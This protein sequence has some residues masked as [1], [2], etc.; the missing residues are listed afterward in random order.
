MASTPANGIDVDISGVNAVGTSSAPHS[1]TL[2]N[3]RIDLYLPNSSDPARPTIIPFYFNIPFGLNMTDFHLEPD[4]N[5]MVPVSGGGGSGGGST[6][7]CSTATI[8]VTNAYDGSPLANAVVNIGSA[9][10]TTDSSGAAHFSNLVAGEANVSAS[11]AGY[12]TGSRSATLSCSTPVSLGL[13][14]SPASGGGAI[15]FNEARI[16]LTWGQN[17]NDLDSHLTGPAAGNNGTADDPNRFH[18]YFGHK[19]ADVANLDVD[20]TTSYGPE[21]ITI[22]PPSGSSTPRPGVYRYSV[23][24]YSGSGNIATSG[25]SVSLN[26]ANGQIREFTPPTDTTGLHGGYGDVWTVFELNVGADGT[27]TLLPINTYSTATSSSTVRST[28]TGFGSVEN[29]V[30]FTRLPAK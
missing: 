7:A 25:A 17:P 28:A 19:Q 12:T 27:V 30:D 13:A 23:F 24:H 16:I 4:L 26:L 5:A 11:L 10:A 20:D 21:T 6:T 9:S 18:I 15:S 14:L 3:V 2:N 29:G 8:M 1:L 22:G